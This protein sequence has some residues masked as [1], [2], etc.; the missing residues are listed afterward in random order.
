MHPDKFAANWES[1]NG[2]LFFRGGGA[3]GSTP[4]LKRLIRGANPGATIIQPVVLLINLIK[5]ATYDGI[6]VREN[7]P[8]FLQVKFPELMRFV[9][10]VDIPEFGS[11]FYDGGYCSYHRCG[12]TGAVEEFVEHAE[13]SE[14]GLPPSLR[15][16]FG[17]H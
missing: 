9:K 15:K 12:E 2:A 5:A 1:G 11:Y 10:S 6:S 3:D 17:W 16:K 4:L 7:W 13:Q 8:E 14:S